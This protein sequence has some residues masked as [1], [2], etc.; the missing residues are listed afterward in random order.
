[1]K[2]CTWNTHTHIRNDHHRHPIC[3]SCVCRFVD[4]ERR[5]RLPLSANV[6]TYYEVKCSVAVEC[7]DDAGWQQSAAVVAAA[8]ARMRQIYLFIIAFY[9]SMLVFFLFF[10][11]VFNFTSLCFILI[12]IRS[13]SLF[14]WIVSLLSILSIRYTRIRFISRYPKRKKKIN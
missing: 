14:L 4:I 6:C 7:M 2:I 10:G 11:C 12:F 1:M 8:V 3:A 13:S 5:T 9:N